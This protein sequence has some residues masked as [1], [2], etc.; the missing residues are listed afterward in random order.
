MADDNKKI[1]HVHCFLDTNILLEFQTFNEVDWLKVLNAKRVCLVLAP[2]VIHELDKHKSD[3]TITRRQKRARMLL[4]KISKL[5]DEVNAGESVQVRP[6]VSLNILTRQP[7]LGWKTEDWK[8]KGLDQNDPDDRLLASIL[9]YTFEHPLEQVFLLSDDSGPR[10][11]AKSH[12]VLAKE[13][14]YELI[15]HI[16]PPSTEEKTIRELSEKLAVFTN[17]MPKLRFGF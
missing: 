1:P 17:R 4:S 13:P 8:A 12:N 14:P 5:F 16:E 3:Y 7:F 15:R 2:I 10:F 9:D 6:N 11:K